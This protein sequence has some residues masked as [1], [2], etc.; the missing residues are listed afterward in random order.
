MSSNAPT[1]LEGTQ[2]PN[3]IEILWETHRKKVTVFFWL[4]LVA[5][6]A[7]YGIQY[8]SQRQHDQKW[9]KFAAGA[10]LESGYAPEGD[11]QQSNIT[12]S[13]LDALE[14]EDLASL[15]QRL[16]SAGPA[17]RPYFLWLIANR[18]VQ[19]KNWDRARSALAELERDFPKH[20]LVQPSAYPVQ[21]RDEVEDKK[22]QEQPDSGQQPKEPELE[23]AKE[24]SMVGLLR[25]RIEALE[26]FEMP[27][28]F[29]RP[30]I[31]ETAPRYRVKISGPSEYEFVIALM[32]EQAPEITKA[33]EELVKTKP[34][35]WKDMKVDEINRLPP[36][37]Q[38][39]MRSM[40]A[41]QFHFGFEST[42][43]AN[44]T[45]WDTTKP[46]EHLV[47]E[48]TGLSHFPGAVAA[49]ADADGKSQID[50]L[51][52][53]ASDASIFDGSRQVFAYV[54]EGMD[55][56][57]QITKETLSSSQEEEMGRGKP[58]EDLK[59]VSIEPVAR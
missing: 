41:P 7:Y 2:A 31:P 50:R 23:P 37:L 40:Q 9:S 1:P 35:H 44:R 10:L 6:A 20:P 54:V 14:K 11:P 34:D 55:A 46:S 15:E 4:L 26:K 13:L 56:V 42:R 16:G 36:K 47:D 19:L 25:A 53:T 32:T 48:V 43:K 28:Q 8:Y 12:T 27:A 57:E 30:A 17:E 29:Q 52:I 5:L 59:I 22:E 51:W 45:E 39:W 58:A 24:G 18:A 38:P 49:R 33:F 21:V 3:T